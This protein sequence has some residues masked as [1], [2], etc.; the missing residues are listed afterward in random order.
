MFFLMALEK[1]RTFK[2]IIEKAVAAIP[3]PTQQEAARDYIIRAQDRL[4]TY[5]KA[6]RDAGKTKQRA[7]LAKKVYDRYINVSNNVLEGVYKDVESG[8]FDLY[9]SINNEDENA[10]TAKL[11]PS[12]GKL[13]FDVDFYGRGHFPP[14][15]YH[16]EGHQDAMGVCL[17]LALMRKLQGDNFNL[18]VLDDVLMSVDTNH[19]RE[20]CN[21]LKQYFP[22]TQFVLTT[23]DEIW[24]K[25]MTTVGL[26]ASGNTT[27]FSNW[28]PDHGPTEWRNR[29]VWAEINDS[30][31]TNDIHTAASRLRYYLEYVFREVCGSLQVRVEFKGDGRYELGDILVPAVK[32]FRTLICTGMY[33][34]KSC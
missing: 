13:S 23:H 12:I 14:G 6:V 7:E 15:A 27:R 34:H 25:L 11:T 24:L 4:E 31:K 28:T 29:D 8:F 19:R 10:F 2:M 18:A 3:E 1:N 5:R 32:H 30:L 16:S 26:I 20:I 9:C 33:W 22:D 17:Y 21:L